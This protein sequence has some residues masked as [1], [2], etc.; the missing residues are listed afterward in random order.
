MSKFGLFPMTYSGLHSMTLPVL[1]HSGFLLWL[2]SISDEGSSPEIT[3]PDASIYS[4]R[5]SCILSMIFYVYT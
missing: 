3:L 5:C 2:V 1:A 4:R